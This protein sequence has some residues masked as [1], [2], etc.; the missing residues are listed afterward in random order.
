MTSLISGGPRWENRPKV[1]YFGDTTNYTWCKDQCGLEPGCYAFILHGAVT[2]GWANT[3]YG[4]GF[5]SPEV[6]RPQSGRDSGVK[7]C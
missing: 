7:L 2:G 3:C 4:R 5:G 1:F 6:V